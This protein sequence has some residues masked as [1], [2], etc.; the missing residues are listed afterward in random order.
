MGETEENKTILFKFILPNGE[1]HNLYDDG[2]FDNIFKLP[3]G[4]CIINYVA[5][6]LEYL[7][8]KEKML[9]GTV[10]TTE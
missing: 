1:T 5:P 7:R 2:V 6:L 3:N 10:R 4:T 9:N 8:F